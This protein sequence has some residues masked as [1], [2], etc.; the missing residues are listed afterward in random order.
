MSEKTVTKFDRLCLKSE[1]M[2][3][4]LLAQQTFFEEH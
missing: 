4:N 3:A 2:Q 1:L